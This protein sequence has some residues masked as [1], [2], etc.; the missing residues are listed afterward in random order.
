MLVELV[1]LC[2]SVNG[3]NSFVNGTGSSFMLA[4]NTAYVA[5]AIQIKQTDAVGNVSDIGKNTLRIVISCSVSLPAT[6]VAT[7]VTVSLSCTN[8]CIV[9]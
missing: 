8:V 2:Q 1:C 4:N 9:L 7:M 3:G 5:N 6:S